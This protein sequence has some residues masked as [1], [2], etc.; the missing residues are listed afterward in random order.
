MSVYFFIVEK[1]TNFLLL[2]IPNGQR[3]KAAKAMRRDLMMIVL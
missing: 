1:Y 3:I 2:D